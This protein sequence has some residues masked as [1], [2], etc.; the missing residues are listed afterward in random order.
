MVEQ[1]LLDSLMLTPIRSLAS[2]RHSDTALGN[3]EY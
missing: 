3:S 2:I 1:M